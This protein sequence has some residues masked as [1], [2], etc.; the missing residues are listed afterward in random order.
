MRAS[1]FYAPSGAMAET[2]RIVAL[3]AS[4]TAGYGAGWGRAWPAQLE[5]MLRAK[6]YDVTVSVQGVVGDTSE[7]NLARID[8]A[9]PA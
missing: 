3:G 9:V 1:R 6:G 4:N 8:S 2:S 7:R 5:S